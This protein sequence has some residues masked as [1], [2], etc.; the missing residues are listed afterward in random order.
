MPMADQGVRLTRSRERGSRLF[1]RESV[2]SFSLTHRAR[3]AYQ[4]WGASTSGSL[5]DAR[6]SVASARYGIATLRKRLLPRA[7]M[8]NLDSI[9]GRGEGI[10]TVI[11]R[12]KRGYA[13]HLGKL[14][15]LVQASR[16]E[17]ELFCRCAPRRENRSSSVARPR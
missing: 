7:A 14:L 4:P 10:V 1:S 6:G 11:L 17:S 3:R 2:G 9:A 13:V 15:P 8:P 5:A 16:R 12:A